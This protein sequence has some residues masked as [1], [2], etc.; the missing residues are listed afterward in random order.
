LGIFTKIIFRIN[1]GI[2]ALLGLSYLSSFISPDVFWPIALFGLA[3]PVLLVLN[4]LFVVYWAVQLNLRLLFSLGIII[5]GWPFMTRY[6]QINLPVF[7]KEKTESAYTLKVLSYNVRLFNVYHWEKSQTVMADIF[8]FIEKENPDIICFQDF[9]TRKRGSYSETSIFSK[10]APYKYHYIKYSFQRENLSDFGIAIFSKYPIVKSSDITFT[11]SY[12]LC[13]Y[14]DIKVKDDTIRVFNT[15]LQSIRFLKSDYNYI[16]SMRLRYDIEI[17]R[18]RGIGSRLKYA[19]KQR[20]GQA[21]KLAKNIEA[22]PYPVL[23]CGDFNDTPVSYTYHL[24]TQNLNDGFV[25]A[26]FGL[27]HTYRGNFPSYRIDYILYDKSLT[28]HNFRI[29]GVKLSDHY[30]V[31]CTITKP[32]L[33]E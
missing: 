10:L 9:Y 22:S 31:M 19:F 5:A 21:D 30:P 26:G 15:H 12:N 20:A 16:D 11:K 1:L 25:Q 28:A 24:L 32:Q 7:G 3:Y 29:P 27:G 18:M 13:I 33:E 8:R 4:I 2:A 23:V 6:V 14:S 17:D